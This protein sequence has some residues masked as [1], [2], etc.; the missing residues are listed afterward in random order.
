MCYIV[1]VVLP[2]Q[3]SHLLRVVLRVLTDLVFHAARKKSKRRK[4]TKDDHIY[5]IFGGD[6]DDDDKR[7]PSRTPGAAPSFVS[8]GTIT[9]KEIQE[10]TH[11]HP[12]DSSLRR[13]FEHGFDLNNN[14]GRRAGLG[15]GGGGGGGGGGGLGYQEDVVME[16]APQLIQAPATL[17]PDFGK[18][19]KFN[20][21]IGLKLLKK[22]GFS[23]GGL[24]KDGQ[25]ISA[26]VEV[27]VRPTQ[28]GLGYG[29]FK[30]RTEQSLKQFGT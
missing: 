2:P 12:T 4:L 25:G 14:N 19:E 26:P 24:G 29:D 9:D 16:D 22:M 15:S 7:Y 23:G 27:K 18:F 30:E 13:E 5:G 10:E 17:D 20:K 28:M 3:L 21:G 8:K 6:E 1:I 11:D